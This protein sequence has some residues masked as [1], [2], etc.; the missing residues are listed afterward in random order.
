MGGQAWETHQ[1]VY[2]ADHAG[3]ITAV[4]SILKQSNAEVVI[5]KDND[6][7]RPTFY[8]ARATKS[9]VFPPTVD[10]RGR[11]YYGTMEYEERRLTVRRRASAA[12]V[13]TPCEPELAHMVDIERDISY[14]PISLP[15]ASQ[16][17]TGAMIPLV[18]FTDSKGERRTADVRDLSR[19][20][21]LARITRQ[22]Y[23]DI[24]GKLSRGRTGLPPRVERM[25]D[26]LASV[27][28]V[29]CPYAVSLS[30]PK[31]VVRTLDY[32]PGEEVLCARVLTVR[33][34]GTVLVRVDLERYAEALLFNQDGSLVS[35]FVFNRQ[36]CTQRNDILVALGSSPIV[37]LDFERDSVK[38]TYLSWNL[39]AP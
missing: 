32:G 21:F 14:E 8:Y 39:R 22:V 30:G 34:T 12:F 1:R 5:G 15:C 28:T 17:Q 7:V 2:T 31:G 20:G 3:N 18:R 37:E 11:L 10:R 16:Q 25:R 26:S 36:Q 9:F 13:P 4:D 24:Q 29:G 33:A 23:R 35:R 38:G 6:A 27:P 19:G